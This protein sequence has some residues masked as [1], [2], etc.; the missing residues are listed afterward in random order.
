MKFAALRQ[1]S[2]QSHQVN[3]FVREDVYQ[4]RIKVPLQPL[5]LRGD[6]YFRIIKLDA[7]KIADGILPGADIMQSLQPG[8][9]RLR[10]GLPL[11]VLTGDQIVLQ[12]LPA[13]GRDA[14]ITQSALFCVIHR[15]DRQIP[16]TW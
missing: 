5:A 14:V 3:H 12:I 8:E 11:T 4:E 13:M 16:L 6:Q 10:K 7:V 9:S 1:D 15:L 2:A